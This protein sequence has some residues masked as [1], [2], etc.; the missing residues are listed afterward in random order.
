M[1]QRCEIDR[2]HFLFVGGKISFPLSILVTMPK[3]EP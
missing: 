1:D 3:L 2:G